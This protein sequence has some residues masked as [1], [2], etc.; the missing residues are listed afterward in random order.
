MAVFPAAL[1]LAVALTSCGNS[2]SSAK[3][4]RLSDQGPCDLVKVEDLEKIF[5]PVDN[6]PG[7]HQ[8]GPQCFYM[9]EKGS[10]AIGRRADAARHGTSFE[11]D[12]V[13]AK[14][15]EANGTCAVDVWLVP[16]DLDQQFGVVSIG[17]LGDQEPCDVSVTVAR[18]ILK[19]LPG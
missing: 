4:K 2:S 10:P 17:K 8:E 5:G 12:G 15:F 7:P 19:S 16:G 1:L 11:I 6:D 3:N 14:K 13:S 9:F 18:L